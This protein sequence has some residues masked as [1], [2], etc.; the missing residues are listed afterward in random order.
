[1][2]ADDVLARLVA[3]NQDHPLSV[4]ELLERLHTAKY[5]GPVILHFIG[6]RPEL[7]EAGRPMRVPLRKT[8]T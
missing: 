6:G 7:V 2:P 3:T 1:M 5:T 4:T 8:G